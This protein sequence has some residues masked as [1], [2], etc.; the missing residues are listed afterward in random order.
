ML[1]F[2]IESTLVNNGTIVKYSAI[3]FKD[4]VQKNQE[5]IF[6]SKVMLNID[7]QKKLNT[8][9]FD[10]TNTIIGT[11]DAK[12]AYISDKLKDASL[13]AKKV[14]DLKKT[15]YSK[16]L[17]KTV[18]LILYSFSWLSKNISLSLLII[19]KKI[20]ISIFSTAPYH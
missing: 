16:W 8:A 15:Q 19:E 12:F 2:R 1:H 6:K 20:I 5:K 4:N 7:P 11:N 17:K 14:L 9:I 10:I 18:T 3:Q 13:A